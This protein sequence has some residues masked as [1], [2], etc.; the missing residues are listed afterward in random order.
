[1][2]PRSISVVFA[3][4]AL[5][6]LTLSSQDA[7][8]KADSE[9]PKPTSIE[10]RFTDGG[11]MR[12][13]I[14]EEHLEF[15]TTHGK[16][17]IAVSDIRRLDLAHRV[18]ETTQRLIDESITNLGSAQFRLREKASADLFALKEKAYPAV[19]KA[20]QSKDTEVA[21]RAKEL[22]EKIRERVPA[23]RLRFR[24]KDVIYTS[25]SV[26]TGR[27][28][29]SGLNVSTQQFGTVQLKFADVAGLYFLNSGAETELKL[30]GRY[31]L[32]NEVWLDTGIDVTEHVRLTI[33]ATGEIDM[34]ATGG[35]EGQYVGTPRGKK[36]WPGN[37]GLPLE[38]GTLIGKIG[39]TGKVFV[40]KDQFEEPAP[41]SGRLYLRAAGNTYSVQT[42]G[43]YTIKVYG[44]IPAVGGPAKGDEPPVPMKDV[45]IEKRR[46]DKE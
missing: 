20:A 26:I 14:A 10:V 15:V 17:K 43:H 46:I 22:L 41:A 25:D 35:Y 16:L 37:T 1:M 39:E 36:A 3:V 18:S 13:T 40:V 29:L 12:M 38:P 24:E 7:V 33:T 34:Y 9:A 2:Y 30:D 45:R 8:K 4:C 6:V 44:G 28:E 27:L 5:L 42:S 19:L 31:A 21:K 23:Q 32:A 11:V